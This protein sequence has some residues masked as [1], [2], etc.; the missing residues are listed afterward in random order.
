MSPESSF[1]TPSNPSRFSGFLALAS[2]LLAGLILT[3]A[4]AAEFDTTVPMR[5][6]GASTY[7]VTGVVEGLGSMEMLVDTG[8]S[9]M[10]LNQSELEVLL[11]KGLATYV[12]D[13]SGKL[14]DGT[15]R[16]VPV[17]RISTLSLGEHCELRDV[18][19]A[20]FPN[21]TRNLLGLSVLRK[22]EPFIFSMDP[23]RLVLSHCAPAQAGD[24]TP[25]TDPVAV[26]G[27]LAQADGQASAT[28]PLTVLD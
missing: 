4:Q 27:R 3:S 17:Y 26:A 11:E 1:M 25:K 6:R 24:Q 19:A 21:K 18:E 23:P 22:A 16:I 7:Y 15:R 10:T 13:L 28:E 9:Y 5:D 20:V 2:G 14:A 8:A 12:K